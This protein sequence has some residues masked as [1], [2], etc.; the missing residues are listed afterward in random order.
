MLT[1]V[2][3]WFGNFGVKWGKQLREEKKFQHICFEAF[4]PGYTLFLI[5][6]RK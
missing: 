5:L 6:Q 4:F 2:A 1:L 3:T